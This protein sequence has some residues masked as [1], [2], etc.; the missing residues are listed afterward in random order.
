VLLVH[1]H[2]DWSTWRSLFA[3]NCQVSRFRLATLCHLQKCSFAYWGWLRQWSSRFSNL[4]FFSAFK[5]FSSL[6]GFHTACLPLLC[7]LYLQCLFSF[8]CLYIFN[9]G[10]LSGRRET[11]WSSWANN[12]RATSAYCWSR[13]PY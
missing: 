5:L 3:S 9:F 11:P 8:F 6:E 4:C 12:A 13:R 7:N 2:S 10:F 1:Y